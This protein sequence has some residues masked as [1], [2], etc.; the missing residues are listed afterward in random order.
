R[1]SPSSS[2]A[3]NIAALVVGPARS[4]SEGETAQ[5]S[6]DVWKDQLPEVMKVHTDPSHLWGISNEAARVALLWAA[7]HPA[8]MIKGLAQGQVSAFIGPGADRWQRILGTAC[9]RAIQKVVIRLL[10]GFRAAVAVLALVGTVF[11]FRP[12]YRKLRTMG[13]CL[14]LLVALHTLAAGSAGQSRFLSPAAPYMDLLAALGFA[15]ALRR[16][17]LAWEE[18][19]DEAGFEQI[20]GKAA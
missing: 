8:A 14:C 15:A 7:A 20:V 19:R 10:A 2:G 5:A 13:F 1:F 9:S 12:E 4:I 3:Y 18:T 11:L 6:L 17:A 16:S